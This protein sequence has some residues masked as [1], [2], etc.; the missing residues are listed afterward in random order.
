MGLW[1]PFL[2]KALHRGTLE[3][4][5]VIVS[6][7]RLQDGWWGELQEQIDKVNVGFYIACQLE[8]G[9]V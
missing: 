9:N 6:G 7:F 1:G 2:F 4:L 5:L 3:F 8:K